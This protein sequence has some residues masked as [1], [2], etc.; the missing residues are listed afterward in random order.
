[1]KKL[2]KGFIIS[3]FLL[4]MLISI[5]LC[6]IYANQRVYEITFKSGSQGIFDESSITGNY[7]INDKKTSVTFFVNA[8]DVFPN[9]PSLII[10]KGYRNN[11]WSQELPE[12]G[13][14]VT[15]KQVYVAKYIKLVNAVEF[16]VKYVDTN[17]V[18]IAT[19]TIYT[20]ELN[21]EELVRA[22]VIDGYQADALQKRLVVSRENVEIHF[23][24]E[25]EKYAQ[26]QVI[27]EVVNV[28]NY[29]MDVDV[30]VSS[31]TDDNTQ[32]EDKLQTSTI[33][34]SE[35]IS[36][37][38]DVVDTKDKE[39]S[40]LGINKSSL[41]YVIYSIGIFFII[42]LAIILIYM[43]IKKKGK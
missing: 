39:N 36:D 30:P 28:E 25:L 34:D 32:T 27:E 35:N 10:N 7:E 9:V 43:I 15:G 37:N 5:G 12:V 6:N 3:V 23:V 20:T 41:N 42:V 31:E 22:K 14:K 19:P 38:Q 1:M 16:V 40:K 2:F 11:K 26:T 21:Q 18:E 17:G 13:S 4:S 29:P 33:T 8:G 24:Y